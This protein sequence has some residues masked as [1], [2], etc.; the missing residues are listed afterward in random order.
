MDRRF[1]FPMQKPGLFWYSEQNV[2]PREGM[3]LERLKWNL[4]SGS[5][6]TLNK[7]SFV[8]QC[9]TDSN[10]L[11]KAFAGNCA[12]ERHLTLQPQPLTLF[13]L[14]SFFIGCENLAFRRLAIPQNNQWFH[15]HLSVPFLARNHTVKVSS[16]G[17]WN[18]W[19]TFGCTLGKMGDKN[20][21]GSSAIYFTTYRHFPSWKCPCAK[22][23]VWPMFLRLSA[24]LR[25]QE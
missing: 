9:S 8:T 22:C 6:R 4:H 12:R 2:F 23:F 15:D 24:I 16:E 3:C 14:G 5:D 20:L 18:I 21:F 1:S 25:R 11:E 19:N 7:C 13:S 10:V 17:N